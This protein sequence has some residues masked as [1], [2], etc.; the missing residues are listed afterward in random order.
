M[1]DDLLFLFVGSLAKEPSV[2]VN[3][4]YD[5]TVLVLP[6]DAAGSEEGLHVAVD[7]I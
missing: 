4:L 3:L 6:C 7:R 5:C 1:P 2:H